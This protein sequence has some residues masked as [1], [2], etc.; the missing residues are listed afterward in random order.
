MSPTERIA[1]LGAI[2]DVTKTLKGSVIHPAP[3]AGS[4]TS[5]AN[6]GR[7]PARR[8][9]SRRDPSS[10][11]PL[12]A[13]WPRP[14]GRPRAARAHGN[15]GTSHM[16]RQ[17]NAR[18]GAAPATPREQ[19][20]KR[21]GHVTVTSCVQTPDATCR[22]RRPWARRSVLAP[23]STVAHGIRTA[24]A[25]RTPSATQLQA[26]SA[27]GGSRPAAPSGAARTRRS[28]ACH[29]T[30]TQ[31]FQPPPALRQRQRPGRAPREKA[32]RFGGTPDTR[33]PR[34]G[35]APPAPSFGTAT[36]A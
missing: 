20:P 34:E 14:H 33:S 11:R 32:S 10:R 35:N 31:R 7:W 6:L 25:E 13:R 19:P 17:A 8:G 36:A 16:T 28:A 12:H 30:P 18:R 24:S 3:R 9:R 23:G 26:A 29:E 5:G 21:V 4:A 1:L 2:F 22:A 15:F 27:A